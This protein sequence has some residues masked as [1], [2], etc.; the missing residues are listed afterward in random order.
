MCNEFFLLLLLNAFINSVF[1]VGLWPKQFYKICPGWQTFECGMQFLHNWIQVLMFAVV[2]FY[3]TI[4]LL[5]MRKL[6]NSGLKRKSPH[7]I[8]KENTWEFLAAVKCMHCS[9]TPQSSLHLNWK[10]FNDDSLIYTHTCTTSISIRHLIIRWRHF[11]RLSIATED[12]TLYF[13]S[14]SQ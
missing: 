3:S 5:E 10:N 7:L 9:L 8:F 14:F 13:A 11:A 12:G 6:I 1:Y 4:S 2:F